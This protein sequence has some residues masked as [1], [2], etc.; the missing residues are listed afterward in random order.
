M[1]LLTA[2]QYV[3]NVSA[4]SNFFLKSDTNSFVHEIFAPMRGFDHFDSFKE[5]LDKGKLKLKKE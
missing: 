3:E 1:S 2:G 4:S 5:G